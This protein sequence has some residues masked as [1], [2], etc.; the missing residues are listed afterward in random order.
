MFDDPPKP[1]VRAQDAYREMGLDA[2]DPWFADTLA[3]IARGE[4]DRHE[5]PVDPG[6]HSDKPS[7]SG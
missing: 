7:D 5:H 1:L 2:D 4:V 6:A 3:A